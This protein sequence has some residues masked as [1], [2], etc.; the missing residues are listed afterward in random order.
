M[1]CEAM[2]K[3]VRRSFGAKTSGTLIA[4]Q[5]CD[6]TVV[7]Q[8]I[9]FPQDTSLLN[10]ARIKLEAIIDSICTTYA[11]P[12]PRTYRKVAHK[13]YLSIAKMKKPSKPLKMKAKNV[14]LAIFLLFQTLGKDLCQKE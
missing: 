8:Y 10:E 5:I 14:I 12:K 9:R 7:P 1:L 6:A 13:E 4:T 11:L 3:G 2:P